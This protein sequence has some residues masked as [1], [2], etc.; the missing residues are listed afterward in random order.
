[1]EQPICSGKVIGIYFS[2]NRSDS[3]AAPMYINGISKAVQ[4]IAGSCLIIQ[5]KNTQLD[6][7]DSLALNVIHTLPY[8]CI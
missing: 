5:L 4:G 1:M 7:T 8:I 3:D 2:N 6:N